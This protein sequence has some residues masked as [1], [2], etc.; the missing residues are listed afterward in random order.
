MKIK[1]FKFKFQ[2][3]KII[4]KGKEIK[5]KKLKIRFAKHAYLP[6]QKFYNK[7]NYHN[8]REGCHQFCFFKRY[9]IA[10]SS[11]RFYDI[12]VF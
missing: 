3:A 9:S 4:V 11:P 1:N 12:E 6:K 10:F 2:F 8:V 5:F 7:F